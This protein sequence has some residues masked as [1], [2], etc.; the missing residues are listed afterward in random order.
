MDVERLRILKRI[1]ETPK[2]E[3]K[4]H[5]TVQQSD[6]DMPLIQDMIYKGYIINYGLYD[7]GYLVTCSAMGVKEVYD[8]E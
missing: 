3:R 8:G 2:G 1:L 7:Y 5:L 4:N 6:P